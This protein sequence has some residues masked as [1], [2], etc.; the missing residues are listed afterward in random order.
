[1]KIISQIL[2][3]NRPSI[4]LTV[5]LYCFICIA[6]KTMLYLERMNLNANLIASYNEMSISIIQCDLFRIV[7]T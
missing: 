1:M 7:S 5:V 2:G 4:I 3:N 6:C